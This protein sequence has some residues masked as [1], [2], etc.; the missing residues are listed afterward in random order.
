MVREC[1]QGQYNRQPAIEA[2]M[3]LSTLLELEP[4]KQELK[5]KGDSIL[6]NCGFLI[7]VESLILLARREYLLFQEMDVSMSVCLERMNGCEDNSKNMVRFNCMYVGHNSESFT[8]V[9]PC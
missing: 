6:S 9:S 2:L 8:F 5:N 4:L 1:S 3:N 7:M